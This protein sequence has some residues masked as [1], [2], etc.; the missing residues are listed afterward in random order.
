MDRLGRKTTNDTR[1]HDAKQHQ[2]ILQPI[3]GVPAPVVLH[4]VEQPTNMAVPQA[5]CAL[6]DT[7][8]LRLRR[9]RI[10]IRVGE[11]VVSEISMQ[12]ASTPSPVI[13][14]MTAKKT[15]SETLKPL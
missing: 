9:L 14:Y 2:T 5:F 8:A 1:S 12:A 11:C 3:T 7:W 6:R 15:T 13:R 4:D 10:A